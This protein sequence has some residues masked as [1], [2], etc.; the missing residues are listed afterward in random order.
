MYIQQTE[1][2]KNR[3]FISSILRWIQAHNDTVSAYGHVHTVH[4]GT[5]T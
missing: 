4:S 5:H 3:W 2:L 1:I